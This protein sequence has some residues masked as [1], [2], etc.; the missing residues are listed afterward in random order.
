MGASASEINLEE[1]AANVLVVDDEEPI[2]RLLSRLLKRHGYDC[3]TARDA[4]EA[5]SF[6]REGNY[7]L[8]LADMN[9][10]GTSGLDLIVRI[11]EEFQDT[12]TLMV[13][14]VDDAKLAYTALEIG[15]YGYV[16][17]PFGTNEM[18]IAVANA[19]RRRSL[20]I[21][22]RSHRERL[23]EMVRERTK[24]LWNAVR[25]LEQA[26][27]DVRKSRE[28]TIYRLSI[29]AEFR[30]DET[31]RHIQRMSRYCSMLARR[32]GADEQRSE[33][34]R[35]SSVMHDVGKIGIPDQILLKPNPLDDEEREIMERHAELGHRILA[36]SESDLLDLAS[37]IALTHHEWIDGSGYPNAIK[38]D[39][40]PFE[41]R[42]AAIADVFDALTTDRVYR[43]AYPLGEAI[44]I[45]K[46]ERGSHFDPEML[47]VFL[48]ALDEALRIK[49]EY[50]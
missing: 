48:D 10:P 8:V 19:L 18:A 13:T 20:E 29:A 5:L 44:D 26:Q 23:E 43:K 46:A 6:M 40:I 36:G 4:D 49:E 45:M 41:G 1:K 34:I 7:E 15:A 21:E 22:N 25:E 16:I 32:L 27:Q 42:V 50:A 35:L 33:L 39:E 14:G 28:E 2:R 30:D 24:E 9:M 17:K 38:D 47:D 31:A 12:A 37:T 3:T 11:H